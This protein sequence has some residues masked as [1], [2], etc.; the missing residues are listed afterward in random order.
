MNI[1]GLKAFISVMATGSLVAAAREMNTSVSALSR[2]L[3]MLELELD[4]GLFTRDKKRLKPTGHAFALLPEVEKLIGNYE[5]IPAI[6]QEIKRLPS[7]RLRIGVMPRMATC[8]VEPAIAKYLNTNPAADIIIEVQ[9]RRHLERGLLEK[10]IDLGF[11][12][13]PANHENISVK[14]ICQVPA[15][16]MLHPQHNLSSNTSVALEDLANEEFIMMPPNTLLGRTMAEMLDDSR[17]SM[18]SRLQVSQTSSCCNFVANGYG[19]SISD[20]MIPEAVRSSIKLLPLRPRHLFDFGLLFLEG[21]N[22]LKDANDIIEVIRQEAESF[23]AD[24]HLSSRA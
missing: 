18:T 22:E 17:L 8:I 16:V 14:S 11:G 15:V 4:L 10:T 20:T 24:M 21:S 13:I 12:S 19:V 5:E 7:R 6:A 3:S 9:P 1:K 2:Q 23:I